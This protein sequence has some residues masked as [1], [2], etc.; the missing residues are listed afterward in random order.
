MSSRTCTL[1]FNVNSSLVI[2]YFICILINTL[3][4]MLQLFA[5]KSFAAS[6]KPALAAT[7]IAVLR[8]L[9]AAFTSHPVCNKIRTILTLSL[10]LSW[11]WGFLWFLNIILQIFCRFRKKHALTQKQMQ[12]VLCFRYHPSG[13]VSLHLITKRWRRR[14][15][16]QRQQQSMPWFLLFACYT[17]QSNGRVLKEIRAISLKQ[18]VH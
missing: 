18:Y 2:D 6:S 10:Q 3:T 15:S 5:N 16:P 12:E 9:F 7:W 4:F 17:N 8:S 14:P 11:N 1:L 13:L